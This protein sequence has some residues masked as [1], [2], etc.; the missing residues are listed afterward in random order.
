M[1]YFVDNNQCDYFSKYIDLRLDNRNCGSCTSP[2]SSRTTYSN[3]VEIKKEICQY[4]NYGY[5]VQYQVLLIPP[6]ILQCLRNFLEFAALHFV[7]K[8]DSVSTRDSSGNPAF[9]AFYW[10]SAVK[11]AVGQYLSTWKVIE[12]HVQMSVSENRSGRSNF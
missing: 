11:A 1:H 9:D 12:C 3:C 7:R 5:P 6:N 2:E 10:L 4:K 8:S